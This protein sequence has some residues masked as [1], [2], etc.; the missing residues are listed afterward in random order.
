VGV[1][2]GFSFMPPMVMLMA[3]VTVWLISVCFMGMWVGMFM[4][5]GV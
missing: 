3:V 4:G 1:I 5:M 2:V